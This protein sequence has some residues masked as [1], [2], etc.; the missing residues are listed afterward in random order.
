[1]QFLDLIIQVAGALIGL[2]F[3]GINERRHLRSLDEREA[4][5]RDVLITNLKRIHDPASVAQ[6]GIVIGQVVIATDSFKS[7]TSQLRRI[8][9]GEMMAARPLMTRARREALLRLVD[10]A[11]AIGASEV[12]NVRFGFCNI[13]SM[14]GRQ[15]ALQVEILA[16]GTA[17]RRSEQAA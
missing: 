4:M 17:V 1:M 12:W 5:N 7:L 3:G 13:A 6:C 10:E 11:R 2:V 14:N 15:G 8:V 9:G 16:V